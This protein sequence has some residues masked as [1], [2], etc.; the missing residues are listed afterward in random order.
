M[1]RS[2]LKHSF[3]HLHEAGQQSNALPLIPDSTTLELPAIARRQSAPS[4]TC[5]DTTSQGCRLPISNSTFTIPIVVG[6]TV[7]IV[8][9]LLALL[10]LHRRHVK[11]LRRE[12][13]NDPTKDLDFGVDGPRPRRK[14]K[15]NVQQNMNLEKT[16]HRGRG[17][18]MDIGNPY[19][20]PPGLQSS[21]ESLHSLSRTLQ[22]GH[23][24]YRPATTY[25][26]GD[27]SIASYPSTRRGGDDSSSYTGSSTHG[28]KPNNSSLNLVANAQGMSRS[29]PPQQA[30]SS[31]P[32]HDQSQAQIPSRKGLPSNPRT[33][34]QPA[35]SKPVRDSYTRKDDADLRRSNNY[36]ASFIH[37]RDPSLEKASATPQQI[38][39]SQNNRDLPSLPSTSEQNEDPS[40]QL[41]VSHESIPK[42]PRKESLQTQTLPP[43]HSGM[44]YDDEHQEYTENLLPP[45][46]NAFQ[47]SHQSNISRQ[48]THHPVPSPEVETPFYTPGEAE[49]YS[50]KDHLNT[51]NTGYDDRRI[52]V[53]RPLPP[54]D[55]A[56]VNPE[57]RA[58]R[59]RSF[60]KEYFNDSEP[61][62]A[63]APPPETYY[64][65]YGQEYHGDGAIFD[66]ASGGYVVA[67]APYAEP[68]TRRAMTPPPRAPPRFQSPGHHQYNSSN[69]H[70]KSAPRSRAFSSASASAR[71][72]PPIP[73]RGPPKQAVPTPG[74]L[75]NLPTPHL[76]QEDAF[77]LPI[78]FAPP[79]RYRDR[80][81]GRPESPRMQARPYSPSVRAH[82]PLASAFDELPVM[83]SPHQLRKS[84]A[85]TALDF[86]PPP[87]FKNSDAGSDAGSIRSGRSTS[88]A[89]SA[90]QMHSVRAGAYRVS[91]IPKE[92]VGTRDELS[93]SLRP[94]WDLNR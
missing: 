57:Q 71:F 2:Y 34:Q 6:V 11:K 84:G 48:I 13:A 15:K 81:M 94:K 69:P 16:L 5:T 42:P 74:P 60:Y 30:I 51:N 50:Y 88:S 25:F 66:P 65:D 44:P 73:G 68:I 35:P 56:D 82:T 53:V 79:S 7:P 64:E 9:A 12:D 58:N 20:L 41:S 86:A 62:R 26:P 93:D 24:P 43:L 90:V 89:M 76:L 8:F 52:S 75:R 31:G 29:Q 37:S 55:P 33:G 17:M 77:A 63:Y 92:M 18:S 19:L 14:T 1:A 28:Y 61:A 80:Q 36:L 21:R 54:V 22:E 47:D 78:D 85:F 10:I 27:A 3:L 46:P 87:R 23:D 72:G 83:P 45:S 49:P 67:Q 91:R 39:I 40:T 32:N 4:S 70:P 38:L 59:I